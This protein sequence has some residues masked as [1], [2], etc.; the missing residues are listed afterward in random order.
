MNLTTRTRGVVALAAALFAS[1]CTTTSGQAPTPAATG[2]E[3]AASGLLASLDRVAF[4]MEW[5]L[6]SSEVK[7]L[8]LLADGVACDCLDL[9]VDTVTLDEVRETKPKRVGQWRT[10]GDVVEVSWGTKW[11]KLTFTATG[12]PLGDGWRTDTRYERY[13]SVGTPGVDYVGAARTLTLD[14]NGRFRSDS[15][16]SLGATSS[17]EGGYEVAGWMLVLTYDNGVVVRQSAVTTKG[18]SK[19]IYLGGS[20]YSAR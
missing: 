20:G 9:E 14:S 1:G 2:T 11:S 15:A 19:A 17:R 8:L 4:D 3:T 7:P 12:D 16:V 5:G 6:S 10:N 18:E 13:S